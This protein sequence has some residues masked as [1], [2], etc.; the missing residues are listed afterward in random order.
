M[1]SRTSRSATTERGKFRDALQG[2]ARPRAARRAHRARH[3]RAAR[4]GGAR[5]VARGRA[6]GVR[7]AARR[8]AGA[9]RREPASASSTT[10]PTCASAIERTLVD[11]PPALAR[12]GGYV[13]DGVDA[14]L[15]ELRAHQPRRASRSSPR[16]RT[17]ERA[18]TGIA[19][20]QGPLQPRVR[21]LHR[22]VEVEPARGAARLPPQAD[23]RRRRA[24]HHAGAEGVRREGA[25][26]RRAD[27]R[28]RDRDVRGAARAGGRRGAAHPGHR[29]RRWPRSTCW[30]RSP[31]PPRSTTTSSRT[32]TTA[33]RLVVVDG[34][35]PVVERHCPDPFVPND[36]QLDGSERQLVILTG[37]N[38]G[39][40]STYLR[41]VAL[42]SV[43][44]AGR[45][46]RAG[47]RGQ[48]RHRRSHLRPRRRLRQHRPRPV[49]LHG[50]DAGDGEHPAHGDLA[51]PGHP[52][53]D[54]PRHG[55][56]RRA[57]HRLGGGGAPGHESPAPGRRR[58]SPRTTTS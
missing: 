54:R 17:R 24:L 4:P 35:H 38:M 6:R 29:A 22:G 18:R 56:L 46:V 10:S 31:R 19:L 20:A 41:Q 23:H 40:K 57:E 26:R 1:R 8:A 55:H 43:H 13:R 34:R 21:L 30:R 53:R 11:E 52:R 25:R 36:I 47:A 14:E 7:T 58:S 3:R 12:D 5:R 28:A 27:P 2:R 51:Q 45:L 48:A 32:S 49:H 16:W 9:A 39:G 37:P 44:G 42:I 50:G 33:T 15:D